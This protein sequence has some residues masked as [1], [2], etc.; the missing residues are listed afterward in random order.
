M[1]YVIDIQSFAL[2]RTLETVLNAPNSPDTDAKK[3]LNHLLSFR[4]P[5][6]ANLVISRM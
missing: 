3:V 6:A 5:D 1:I 2:R 4:F